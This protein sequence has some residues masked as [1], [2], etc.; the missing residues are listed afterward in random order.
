MVEKL[1]DTIL[2]WME[3]DLLTVECA[4]SLSLYESFGILSGQDKVVTAIKSFVG[5]W[6][7]KGD[8]VVIIGCYLTKEGVL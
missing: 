7:E 8:A 6:I 5:G 4:V 2:D 3:N 1:I